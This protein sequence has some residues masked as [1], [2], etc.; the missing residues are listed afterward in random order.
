[1]N[2]IAQ[3]GQTQGT[4]LS[5]CCRC[6]KS[7][8]E[9]RPE[10]PPDPQDQAAI[11][12]DI[13]TDKTAT[14]TVTGRRARL[15]PTITLP[16]LDPTNPK[17]MRD[18]RWQILRWMQSH[19]QTLNIP[20]RSLVCLKR[21]FADAPEVILR[22]LRGPK[23]EIVDVASW[24]GLARCGCRQTCVICGMVDGLEKADEVARQGYWWVQEG[25]TLGILTLTIPHMSHDTEQAQFNL[26]NAAWSSLTNSRKGKELLGKNSPVATWRR[27][28]E[29]TFASNWIHGHVHV[30]LHLKG[31][32]EDARFGYGNRKAARILRRVTEPERW[33]EPQNWGDTEH[34]AVAVVTLWQRTIERLSPKFLGRMVIPS[35]SAQD[36]TI[37]P[38]SGSGAAVA[39]YTAKNSLGVGYEMSGHA[40]LGRRDSRSPMQLLVDLAREGRAR[41]LTL[42]RGHVA[43]ITGRRMMST[44]RGDRNPK[45]ICVGWR[46]V[47]D[48]RLERWKVE[49]EEVAGVVAPV[50]YDEIVRQ[51]GELLCL[52][53]IEAMGRERCQ[54]YR[55]IFAMFLR[56]YRI[57]M[58]NS[59]S[60]E[61]YREAQTR[62]II[63]NLLQA[64][65]R[66]VAESS[67]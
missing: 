7:A 64:L 41:D 16:E 54:E 52:H 62:W 4:T 61:G 50:M 19:W 33:A 65:K 60:D 28:L 3:E 43:A 12:L 49:W 14:S 25:N 56:V 32:P 27:A 36:V 66:L 48:L 47:P 15:V 23:G 1:M 24:R 26:L 44:P 10:T 59:G 53:A 40:K 57:E 42:W 63:Y 18:L 37:V 34:W 38:P 11:L 21:A 46:D 31:V 39:A 55:D 2:R 6:P 13:F 22:G 35:M 58:Y 45:R 29:V 9:K 20:K 30:L 17:S 51:G 67:S 5:E 8:F